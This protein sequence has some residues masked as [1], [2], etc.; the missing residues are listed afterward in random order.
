MPRRA[1]M[2][3]QPPAGT[4]LVWVKV[5]QHEGAVNNRYDASTALRLRLA[6]LSSVG[7]QA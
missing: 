1:L 7:F 5:V 2:A 6:A 4:P 3:S